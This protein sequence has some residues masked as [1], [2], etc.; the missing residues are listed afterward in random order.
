[1]NPAAVTLTCAPSGPLVGVREDNEGLTVSGVTDVMKGP[2]SDKA[3]TC[4]PG[5][6]FVGNV[7][8]ATTDWFG[9]TVCP[10]WTTIGTPL[11]MTC[12]V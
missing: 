6:E 7:N 4:G 9:S 5:V 8:V 1:M 10:L 2:P 11:T 12:T 3:I